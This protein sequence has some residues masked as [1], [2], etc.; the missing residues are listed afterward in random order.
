MLSMAEGLTP[1]YTILSSTDPDLWDGTEDDT[2]TVPTGSADPDWDAVTCDWEA[3]GYRLPTRM[4]SMW[5]AMGATSDKISADIVGGINTGGYAKDF[6]GSS[7]VDD[8][9][10]NI[11]DYAWYSGN[12]SSTTHEVGTTTYGNELG[13]FD[14]SGNV[15]KWC[16]DSEESFPTS[17]QTDY[18]GAASGWFATEFS[19]K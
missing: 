5:V 14:M 8:S 16:W 1:A 18:R 12:S 19:R 13:L 3:S 9:Y 6:A 15:W 2:V 7:T 4:E 10:T 11:G 17:N